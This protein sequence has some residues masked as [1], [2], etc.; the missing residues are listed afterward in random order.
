MTC[1]RSEQAAVALQDG[2][3]LVVAGDATFPGEPPI[4][5]PVRSP[6]GRNYGGTMTK[7][8]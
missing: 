4:A 6:T 3:A 1:P 8:A 2:G 5:K 7:D